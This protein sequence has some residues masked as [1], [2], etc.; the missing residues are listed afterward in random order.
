ML[1]SSEIERMNDHLPSTKKSL[2]QLLKSDSPSVINRDNKK[3]RFKKKSLEKISQILPEKLW[4]EINLPIVLLSRTDIE[5]GLFSISGGSVEI[6]FLHL[7]LNKTTAMFSDFLRE[8]IKP[9]LWKPEAFSA[10]KKIPT[11]VI[12]GYV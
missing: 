4:D 11:A 7:L 12:I 9:Y 3:H 6:Y 2:R 8:K 1:W 5:K 10:V